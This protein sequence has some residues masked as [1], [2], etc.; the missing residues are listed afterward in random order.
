V[1]LVVAGFL[2][3]VGTLSTL[4]PAVSA[5]RVDPVTTLKEENA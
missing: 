2:A 4:V 1:I 3:V 5:A